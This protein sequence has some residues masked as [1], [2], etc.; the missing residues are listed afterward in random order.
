MNSSRR[1]R[2][3]TQAPSSTHFSSILP[4]PPLPL[5][6]QGGL[7]NTPNR[8]M[9]PLESID[10]LLRQCR[11]YQEINSRQKKRYSY[12]TEDNSRNNYYQEI[13]TWNS[14]LSELIHNST[15]QVWSIID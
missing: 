6:L 3:R 1:G 12:G 9:N 10:E 4:P 11:S 8:T 2:G 15:Q 13:M 7:M 5:P 14:H